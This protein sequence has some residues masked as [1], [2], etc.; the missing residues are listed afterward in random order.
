MYDI[1]VNSEALNLYQQGYTQ[2]EIAIKLGCGERTVRRWLSGIKKTSPKTKEIITDHQL[3]LSYLK[4][5]FQDD[6]I[7]QILFFISLAVKNNKFNSISF[8]NEMNESIEEYDQITEPWLAAI[9]GFTYLSQITGVQKFAEINSL[10]K[11]EKPFIK[12]DRKK[13]RR[14]INPLIKE[15]RLEL[16]SL[17]DISKIKLTEFK[18]D[19]PKQSPSN[20]N[21]T[22]Y[23]VSDLNILGHD[24]QIKQFLNSKYGLILEIESRLPDLDIKQQ[25]AIYDL[26]KIPLTLILLKLFLIS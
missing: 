13:F 22:N 4:N 16:I 5:F 15:L 2:K 6:Y 7:P 8:V 19:I 20:L 1:D 24:E 11:N 25:K 23:F 26:Q 14:R 9:S 18:P 10:I 21:Q 12:K 3:N 17:F